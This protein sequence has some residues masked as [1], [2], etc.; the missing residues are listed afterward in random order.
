M[1]IKYLKTMTYSSTFLKSLE[2]LVLNN[3]FSKLWK[4]NQNVEAR[5]IGIYREYAY[6]YSSTFFKT[7]LA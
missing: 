1:P 6:F 7:F 4:C 2:P 3:N 5:S